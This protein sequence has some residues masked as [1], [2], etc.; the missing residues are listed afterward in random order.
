MDTIQDV[1]IGNR[2]RMQT[3]D[4][5]VEDNST[6]SMLL[7][8]AVFGGNPIMQMAG[9]AGFNNLFNSLSNNYD[10]VDYNS[11]YEVT[12]RYNAMG[13]AS[14]IVVTTDTS[15]EVFVHNLPIQK[16]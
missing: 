7:S 1:N 9:N 6:K 16:Q 10:K 11:Y 3:S 13:E 5:K 14:K 2:V 15:P 12:I 8:A 4:K